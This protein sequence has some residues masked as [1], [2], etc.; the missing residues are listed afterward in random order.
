MY[1]VSV[2]KGNNYQPHSIYSDIQ[3]M[4]LALMD[5]TVIN[6]FHSNKLNSLDYLNDYVNNY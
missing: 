5:I 6:E 3:S 2:K 4:K 1:V